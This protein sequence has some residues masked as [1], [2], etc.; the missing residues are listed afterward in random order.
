MVLLVA[1]AFA[2]LA[3]S[4]VEPS[5][6]P[7]LG[8]ARDPAPLGGAALASET[9][10]RLVVA[11]N[12]PFVLDVDTGSTTPVP[13]IAALDSGVLWVVGVGGRAAAVVA[14]RVWRRADI[15]AVRGQGAELSSLGFG[16]DV[17][18][19]AD[20]RSVWIKRFLDRSRCTLRRVALDGRETRAPRPLPCGST[21]APGGSLG[22]VVNRT[23]VLDPLTGRTVLRTRWGILAAVGRKLVLAGPSGLLTLMD[24]ATRAERRLGPPSVHGWLSNYPTVDPRGRYV[25]LEFGDPSWNLTGKQVLDGWLLDTKTGKL[26][27]LPGMPALVELKRTSMAWTDDGRLVLLARSGGQDLVAVWRPGQRRLAI[28]RVQLPERNSGSDSFAPVG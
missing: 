23:R 7:Q 17:A 11:D 24:P 14:S 9:G 3:G 6:L 20:G 15:Y 2:G 26:T 1:G 28:K 12:P 22:L 16:S 21:I 18:P 8:R 5:D 10:L 25:V 13:G 27:Q 4:A 19:A